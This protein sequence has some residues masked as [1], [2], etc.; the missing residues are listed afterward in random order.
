MDARDEQDGRLRLAKLVT[1][2]GVHA[3]FGAVL[4]SL[5]LGI[6]VYLASLTDR[7]ETFYSVGALAGVVTALAQVVLASLQRVGAN[8][9][10]LLAVAFGG[11][12]LLEE[13]VRRQTGLGSGQL[14]GVAMGWSV[15][16]WSI[17]VLV[18]RRARVREAP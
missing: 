4:G 6:G 13:L 5:T 12:V 3:V 11:G 17:L 16:A 8:V 9:G 1:R 2:M 14:A 18:R 10:R 7:L 15:V